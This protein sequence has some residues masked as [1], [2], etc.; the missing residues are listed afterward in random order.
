MAVGAGVLM[1]DLSYIGI[2]RESTYGIYATGTAGINFLSAS[3]KV[4]QET[5]ILEEIQTSRTNSNA[6]KLGRTIEGEI[7]TYFSPMIASCNYLLQNA[8]GGG[9]VTSATATGETTG[10]GGFTH[11]INIANF[12]LTYSS[13]SINCRKGDSTTGKIFEYSG[14]RVN[15]MTLKAEIDE[16][17]IAN[18]AL[19][20][21]DVTN[22][23]ND[24]SSS[25]STGTQLPLSFVNGRFS[26]ET[27]NSFTT[28]S[29]WNVQSMEF[30]ISNN[31]ISDTA[32]RR[33]GSDVLQVLPAGLATFELKATIRFD[34]TTAID[35]MKA[36]TRLF[37]EFEFLGNTMTG[38]AKQEGIKLTMP[39]LLVMDAGDPEIGGPNEPLTS[40][41][42]FAVLRDPTTS[43]YAVRAAV[44]NLTASY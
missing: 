30:K 16:A 41:V 40:E 6:I 32:A 42:S 36:G 31:L 23:S 35:A 19:I 21:K 1:G 39:Y 10:G 26:I 12:D 33:I 20:G 15:E 8:F 17:L 37:G 44:T 43:G 3:L 22:S 5:K 27:S 38:S 4:T 25:L 28:T 29:Y 11:T 24:V 14:L 9:P 13:L 7:E 2:G 34:T 18:F